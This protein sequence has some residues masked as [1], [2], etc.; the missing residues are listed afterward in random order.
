MELI[1]LAFGAGILF[2]L[3]HLLTYVEHR[4]NR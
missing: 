4:L 2:L 1:V 3:G